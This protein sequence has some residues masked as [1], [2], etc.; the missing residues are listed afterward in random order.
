MCDI[1]VG[2]WPVFLRRY[3]VLYVYI[4]GPV[5][6]AEYIFRIGVR[7]YDI[8]GSLAKES[9]WSDMYSVLHC[10]VHYDD[11]ADIPEVSLLPPRKVPVNTFLFCF[12]G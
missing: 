2:L 8:E 11:I 7:S 3:S 9:S 5:Y 6:F 4:P 12:S 1:Y 10:T